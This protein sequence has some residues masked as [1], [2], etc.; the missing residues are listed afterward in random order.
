MA[1]F[2]DTNPSHYECYLFILV[3]G[4]IIVDRDL[5]VMEVPAP[6]GKN[7]IKKIYH[8]LDVRH[9]R[10]ICH[11]MKTLIYHYYQKY[12]IHIIVK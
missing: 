7:I 2:M 8:L 3:H 9:Y 1:E 10:K 12:V 5:K 11:L 4:N 6:E